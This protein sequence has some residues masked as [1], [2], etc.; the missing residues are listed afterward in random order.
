VLLLEVVTVA[1]V[2][3][4]PVPAGDD[5]LLLCEPVEEVV[6][7]EAPVVVVETVLLLLPVDEDPGV[8]AEELRH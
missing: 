1:P 3:V 6:L 4:V 2:E 8:E 7:V 5:V